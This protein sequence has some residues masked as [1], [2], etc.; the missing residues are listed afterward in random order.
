MGKY[1]VG[2]AAV[3]VGAGAVYGDL[4]SPTWTFSGP[5]QS[6]TASLTAGG[7]AT[8][9]GYGTYYSWV[10]WPFNTWGSVTISFNNQTVPIGLNPDT[11]NIDKDP[12]GNGKS[13]LEA[14]WNNPWPPLGG[15][16]LGDLNIT[17]F[18][19]GSPQG[20]ALDRVTLDG[21]V[22]TVFG[23]IPVELRLDGSGSVSNMSFNMLTNPAATWYVSGSYPNPTKYSWIGAG[24]VGTDYGI[25]LTGELEVWGLFTVNLGTL[26]SM[27]GHLDYGDPNDQGTWLPLIGDMTYT[28]LELGGPYPHDVQVWI[29]VLPDPNALFPLT[30][31][32]TTTGSYTYNSYTGPGSSYYVMSFNYNFAGSLTIDDVNLD[33]YAT[34]TNILVPE[35]LT[36]AVFGVGAGLLS[37]ARRRSR[38]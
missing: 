27:S 5:Q 16:R 31:P 6:F 20:L 33:L 34:I 2:L 30:I 37:L 25:A 15:G 24:V 8:L 14:G 36:V 21:T 18:M 1:V 26:A 32:F 13:R 12:M 22:N 11:T 29:D 7:S 19:G 28:D 23:D 38:R 17:D 10:G 3:L 35:P 9:S 4:V